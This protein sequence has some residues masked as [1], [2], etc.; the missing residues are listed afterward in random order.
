MNGYLLLI[1]LMHKDREG[2]E[3]LHRLSGD[4]TDQKAQQKI[5][6]SKQRCQR[7][8]NGKRHSETAG[9]RQ[10]APGDGGGGGLKHEGQD[11]CNSSGITLGSDFLAEREVRSGSVLP[12]TTVRRPA[13]K[14]PTAGRLDSEPEREPAGR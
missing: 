2:R 12:A 11:M 9:A 8:R 10:A 13:I 7:H 3:A 4:E 14:R 6:G 1:T 5:Q